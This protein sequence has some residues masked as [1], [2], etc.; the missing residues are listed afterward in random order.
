MDPEKKPVEV[1][2]EK[3]ETK[4]PEVDPDELKALAL[5]YA[6]YLAKHDLEPGE[7]TFTD[8]I[9]ETEITEETETAA[10][11]ADAEENAEAA[12]KPAEAEPTDEAE[13]PAETEKSAETEKAEKTHK[14]DRKKQKK[15][16]TDRKSRK[17]FAAAEL[18]QEQIAALAEELEKAGRKTGVMARVIDFHDRLQNRD[19][20][21]GMKTRQNF[22]KAA[23]NIIS[24]Y[25]QSRRTIGI[26][27]LLIGIIAA[28]ILAVFDRYTV[29]EYAYNGM[30]LGY[31]SSQ[32]EITDVLDVAGTM[33]TQNS[34]GGTEIRFTANENVTFKL[35]DGRDKSLDDADMALNKLVYMTD[36]ETEAFGVYDG[37][38]LAAVVKSNEDAE[39]LLADAKA[40]LSEPDEGMKIVSADFTNQLD[41]RPVN[42]LLTS[43]QSNEDALEMMIEGGSMEIYHIVE[44]G[45][46]ANSLSA[47]FGTDAANIFNEDNSETASEIRQ[48]DKVCIHEIVDPVSVKLV[49]T[50]RMKQTIEYDTVKE[51]SEDYYKGDTHTAQEGVDGIQIFEGTLYKIGGKVSRRDAK[52]IETVR[53]KQDKIILVGTAERPK[54]APT[55]TYR[56]P[57]ENYIISSNFGPRW[58]RLHSGVDMAAP[59]GTPIYATDGGEVIRASY[60][61]GYGNC[62]DI[63]HGNGR[64]TRYGHCS[65]I[66]VNVGDMV[67]QG[68]LIGLVGS[69][70]NSTGNHLHFEI[71]FNDVP[72]DPRPYLGI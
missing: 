67:Y 15:V 70:G 63:D 16:R 25:R 12:E 22:I 6:K 29:Y 60:Y 57:T 66:L 33:M 3:G 26:A 40:V 61:S 14:K 9:P 30:T 54:T 17:L 65:K 39:E 35:V 42:V 13:K 36:I 43:V 2:A 23:H 11:T 37:D 10:E 48:G 71:R 18:S 56:I 72:T 24:T 46:D 53:E 34:S 41:I 69:T 38:K 19:E 47:A 20:E 55:G 62:I 68:Q 28:V 49:E 5:A 27:L 51:E 58:G 52:S 21:A 50:G 1:Y 59:G 32:E 7:P 44:E 4:L 31:V 45:E 64:V 8:T